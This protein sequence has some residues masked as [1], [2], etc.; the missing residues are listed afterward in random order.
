MQLCYIFN[1][2]DQR[3]HDHLSSCKFTSYS[4]RFYTNY[5]KNLVQ[6]SSCDKNLVLSN[7]NLVTH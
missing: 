3:H 5:D 1:Y 4:T 7:Q 2:D 6:D